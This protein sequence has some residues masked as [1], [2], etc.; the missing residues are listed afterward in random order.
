MVLG[1][2]KVYST[3]CTLVHYIMKKLVRTVCPKSNCTMS[4]GVYSET[5]KT[6]LGLLVL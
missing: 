2:L 6:T 5:G 1:Q 3:F 4:V